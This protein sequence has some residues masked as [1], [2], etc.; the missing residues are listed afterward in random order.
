MI[1]NCLTTAPVGTLYC[2]DNEIIF[3]KILIGTSTLNFSSLSNF[4]VT[5]EVLKMQRND[6][7]G[8]DEPGFLFY[9]M[10]YM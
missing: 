2:S 1:I 10:Y 6:I 7:S 4:Q 3:L 8:T 5:E 9:K